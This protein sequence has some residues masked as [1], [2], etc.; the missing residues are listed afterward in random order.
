MN[1]NFQQS[2][3]DQSYELPPEDAAP[4]PNVEQEVK[5]ASKYQVKEPK[6]L[7]SRYERIMLE[8]EAEYKAKV[9]KERQEKEQKEQDEA[10]RPTVDELFGH[11]IH[12][13]VMIKAS[14]H[15]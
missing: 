10:E 11:R 12:C 9:E 15:S 14:F 1:T 3:R 6:E 7:V 5:K 8:K 13:W 4:K 2:K